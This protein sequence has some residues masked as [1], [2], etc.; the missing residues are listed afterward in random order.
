MYSAEK[1]EAICTRVAAGE[2]LRK[3]AAAEGVDHSTFLY[4]LHDRPELANQYTRAREIGADV[5]F[6]ALEELK[7]EQPE[8]GPTGTVDAGWVAWKRLQIDTAKWS[9]SK[10]APK[11]YGEKTE[12]THEVGESVTK[13]VRQIVGV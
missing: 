13:I 9:L 3:A 10:K 1:G 11:K 2:S 5:G 12:T 6:D 7:E 4:W 8:R